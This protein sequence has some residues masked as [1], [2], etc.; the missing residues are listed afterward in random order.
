MRFTPTNNTPMGER[1]RITGRHPVRIE[2]CTY[3]PSKYDAAATCYEVEM[4]ITDGEFRGRKLWAQYFTSGKSDGKLAY[5]NSML[6]HLARAVGLEH[7][8]E[9]DDHT[10]R[11]DELAGKECEAEIGPKQSGNNDEVKKWFRTADEMRRYAQAVKAAP[12]ADAK[13][14]QVAAANPR[15]ASKPD[16]FSDEIPF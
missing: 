1:A 2:L 10:G 11:V 7:G 15:R 16:D 13:P 8:W 6:S 14:S 3:G 12:A 5:D 9:V 4:T